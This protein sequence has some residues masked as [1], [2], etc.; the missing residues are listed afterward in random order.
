MP[1]SQFQTFSIEWLTL[2]SLLTVQS[3]DAVF[4]VSTHIVKKNNN[5]L[6]RTVASE[7]ETNQKGIGL[8][9]DPLLGS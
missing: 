8:S 7:L 6:E 3:L 4:G 1:Y 9:A 2:I 5:G